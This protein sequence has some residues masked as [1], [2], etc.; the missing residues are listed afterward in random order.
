M[1]IFV[2]QLMLNIH[3]SGNCLNGIAKN[4]NKI[5]YKVTTESQHHVKK[6]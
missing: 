3:N 1:S 2:E 5:V 6:L 4:K